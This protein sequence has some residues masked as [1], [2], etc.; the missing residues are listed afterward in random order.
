MSAAT[1][2]RRTGRRAGASGTR[3]AILEAARG[4]FA[5]RGYEG[6]SIRA[7]AADARVDPALVYH[8]FGSKERLFV[9]ATRFPV[10]P[11]EVLE[12]VVDSDPGRLGET[13]V[14]TV[15]GVWESDDSRSQAEALLRSAVTNEQA[16]SMLR[17]FVSS[18]ILR[19]VASAIDDEDAEYRASLVAGQVVGL[20]I[21]RYV[22]AL[23]PL[24]T[25]SVEDLVA[26]IGP[27]LQRYLTG[28]VRA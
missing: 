11:S 2:A 20:G 23:Q 15:L 7:I 10:V 27:A 1:R 16:A 3:E 21:A 14:R 19:I 12:G 28:D 8:F 25:A 9:E 18:T 22:V 17:G 24:A 5:D 4:R 13:I 6:A 26:A